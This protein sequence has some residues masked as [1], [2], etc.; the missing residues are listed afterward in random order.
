MPS[1]RTIKSPTRRK[2][3]KTMPMF[4]AAHEQHEAR[5]HNYQ[6]IPRK[7]SEL[8][9]RSEL[10]ELAPAGATFLRSNNTAARISFAHI[11]SEHL[12]RFFETLGGDVPWSFVTLAPKR[13]A[14]AESEAAKFDVGGLIAWTRDVLEGMHFVGMVEAALY[15]NV[16]A[17]VGGADRVVSFHTHALV[18]GASPADL[19]ALVDSINNSEPALIPGIPPGHQRSLK[20][21]EV[22]GP[23][24]YMLKGP[25]SD[26]RVYPLR[27]AVTDQITGEITIETTGRFRQRKQALRPRDAVRMFRVMS[28]RYIDRLA[29]AGGDGKTLLGMFRKEALKDWRR[30]QLRLN[31]CSGIDHDERAARDA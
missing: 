8:L 17:H 4:I 22:R 26:H 6:H 5:L 2:P 21:R 31:N 25:L 13:F 14:I 30:Y 3:L 24:I 23:M 28:D 18:W 9:S 11:A 10:D 15:T 12:T 27:A 29:F 16:G 1:N 20:A 19:A 7:R